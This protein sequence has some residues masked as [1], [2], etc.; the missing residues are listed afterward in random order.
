M[1]A[2]NHNSN[3][4]PLL[5][6]PP[7]ESQRED[8]KA[9]ILSMVYDSLED[10]IDDIFDAADEADP[11]E[12]LAWNNLAEIRREICGCLA[13]DLTHHLGNDMEENLIEIFS[14][15]S[16]PDQDKTRMDSI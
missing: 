8:A 14:E 7:T 10:F 3:V 12:E 13:H 6:S 9:L 4:I 11:G 16:S 1:N 5:T 2:E 15:Q